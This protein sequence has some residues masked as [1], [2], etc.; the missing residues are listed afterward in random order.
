MG[1]KKEAFKT[2]IISDDRRSF[3]LELATL[4]HSAVH[5]QQTAR[6]YHMQLQSESLFSVP[7]PANMTVYYS[8]YSFK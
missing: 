2:I 8:L 3:K 7:S 4:K 1:Y 5:P 6:V